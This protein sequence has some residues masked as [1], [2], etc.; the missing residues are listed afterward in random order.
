[1]ICL[2]PTG[3]RNPARRPDAQKNFPFNL[4]KSNTADRSISGVDR[5]STVVPQHKIAALR[6]LT[7]QRNTELFGGLIAEIRLRKAFT[8]DRD[9]TCRIDRNIVTRTADHAL[10]QDQPAAGKSNQITAGNARM[11]AQNDHIPIGQS[12]L[13]AGPGYLQHRKKSI[14]QHQYRRCGR[15]RYIGNADQLPAKPA[16]LSFL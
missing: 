14:H 5:N 9:G 3:K 12:R 10:Q 1:M 8:V 4:I 2:P 6:H 13:H 16:P 11:S 15:G 7:E